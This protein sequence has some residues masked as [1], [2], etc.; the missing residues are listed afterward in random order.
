[1][2]I[3]G[4]GGLTAP[5]M[6]KYFV[7]VPCP[8]TTANIWS[9]L[10]ND[11]FPPI[12]FTIPRASGTLSGQSA[13]IWHE[14]QVAGQSSGC[15][16]RA[17]WPG[18]PSPCL[19]VAFTD[20]IC[21]SEVAAPWHIDAARS[22]HPSSISIMRSCGLTLIGKLESTRDGILVCNLASLPCPSPEPGPVLSIHCA[23]KT[24]PSLVAKCRA[25]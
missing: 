1:M 7:G 22:C 11:L 17:E 13:S 8:P 25:P 5:Q 9:P 16:V 12:S 15:G 23:R 2:G 10:S 19:L 21:V 20:A 3:R 6:G 18:T 24:P 14:N 4:N